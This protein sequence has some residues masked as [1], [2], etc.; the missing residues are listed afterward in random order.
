MQKR[1]KVILF[2]TLL[3]SLLGLF[4]I[5]WEWKIPVRETLPQSPC[6]RVQVYGFFL[7][8]HVEFTPNEGALELFLSAMEEISVDR[9]PEWS[10][11]RGDAIGL[12]LYFEWKEYPV[13]LYVCEDGSM[14]VW[15]F[16]TDKVHYFEHGQDLFQRLLTV[17][18]DLPAE[19]LRGK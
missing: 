1:K 9:G 12:L 4:M 19:N 17:T 15:D 11:Y 5:Y 7:D 13:N 14:S 16:E 6:T 8:E 2:F 10:A 3:L 18:K